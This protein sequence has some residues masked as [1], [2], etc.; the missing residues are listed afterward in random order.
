MARLI[1]DLDFG[2]IVAS[3][4]NATDPQRRIGCDGITQ[5]VISRAKSESDGWKILRNA[6]LSAALYHADS[7]DDV[8]F[9]KPFVEALIR[10]QHHALATPIPNFKLRGGLSGP[11]AGPHLNALAEANPNLGWNLDTIQQ[12]MIREILSNGSHQLDDA[13]P[14]W[15]MHWDKASAAATALIDLVT[16]RALG[17]LK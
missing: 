5:G 11:S 1:R 13:Q 16:L 9:D 14:P 7:F 3:I 6:L 10:A 15:L 17:D 12:L 4:A 2:M 8:T